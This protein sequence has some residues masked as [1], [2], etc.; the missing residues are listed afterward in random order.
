MWQAKYSFQQARKMGD[1]YVYAVFF[2]LVMFLTDLQV[3][4]NYFLI[5]RVL[6]CHS[7]SYKELRRKCTK[8][9]YILTCAF[10][11]AA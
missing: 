7:A 10:W 1:F 11:K 3:S 8:Y 6:T 5:G 4:L 9:G 2:F